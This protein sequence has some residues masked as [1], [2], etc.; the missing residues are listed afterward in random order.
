MTTNNI[1]DFSEIEGVTT[2]TPITVKDGIRKTLEWL[3]KT[4]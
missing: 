3:N 4:E 1:I 2:S